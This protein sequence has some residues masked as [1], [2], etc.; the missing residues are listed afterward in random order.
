MIGLECESFASYI[1]FE[2][3]NTLNYCQAL[4]LY[5]WVIKFCWAQL[6]AGVAY[7]VQLLNGFIRSGRFNTVAGT[8]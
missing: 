4:F 6:L 7:R 1:Q 3:S 2:A 8:P 5:D